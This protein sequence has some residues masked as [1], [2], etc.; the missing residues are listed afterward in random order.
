M[1]ERQ[2]QQ[3]SDPLSAD[4]MTKGI[5]NYSKPDELPTAD[6]DWSERFF[7]DAAA[8]AANLSNR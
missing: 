8:A 1:T 7:A 2:F 3:L 4:R 5:V 6:S